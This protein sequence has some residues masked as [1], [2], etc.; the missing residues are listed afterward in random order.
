M[1][2][3]ST[4]P[5]GPI[6]LP[7]DGGEEVERAIAAL[8]GVD[9]ERDAQIRKAYAE[10]AVKRRDEADRIAQSI[11]ASRARRRTRLRRWAIG[12]ATTLVLL[13]IGVTLARP[14]VFRWARARPQFEALVERSSAY[15]HAG[16]A[17]VPRSPWESPSRASLVVAA[18]ACVIA[19]GDA[20]VRLSAG[21]AI[22]EGDRAAALCTCAAAS[23]EAIG[24]PDESAVTLLKAE[25]AMA[26]GAYGLSYLSPALSAVGPALP[27]CS[28]EHLD[29]WVA[30]RRFPLSAGGPWPVPAPWSDAGFEPIARLSAGLPVVALAVPAESCAIAIPDEAP[31]RLAVRSDE[32][33]ELVSA[34][35]GALGWCTTAAS[36]YA[37]LR[38]G[39][40]EVRVAAAPSKRI[41]GMLGLQESAARAG[42][43]EIPIGIRPSDLAASAADAL[44][45]SGIE[46]P[47]VVH[48][49]IDEQAKNLPDARIVSIALREGGLFLPDPGR[50]VP[51]LCIPD[52]LRPIGP[53]M[54]VQTAPHVWS[55][56]GAKRSVGAAEALLPFWM[57]TYSEVTDPSGLAHELAVL[58]LAR[59]LCARHFIPTT[60]EAVTETET[61][62]MVLGRAG[63]DAIVGV[64]LSAKPPW[65][66]PYTDGPAWTLDG[67]PRIVA[68]RPG[69]RVALSAKG[70]VLLP[71]AERRTVVFRRPIVEAR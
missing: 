42:L 61:G 57:M 33:E 8:A 64:G 39:K 53:R 6:D 69:G 27:D 55:A 59:Q 67:E 52:R 50:D 71:L 13:G 45:A 44:R 63:E 47:E 12:S 65:L 60:L 62:V 3:R 19:L 5:K 41:G 29:A 40:G 56:R 31:D 25:P 26:G 23:I 18:P 46:R 17:P 7:D 10:S 2:P 66:L 68:L 32:G 4:P 16:F 20:H 43:G 30:A 11:A 22:V 48:A 38:T 37:L 9:P 24:S 36:S 15:A 35:R 28:N 1:P 14:L 51:Y 54:C 70:S 58:E 21:D 34:T 49:G